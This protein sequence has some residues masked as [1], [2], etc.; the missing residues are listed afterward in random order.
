MMD[1]LRGL[2]GVGRWARVAAAGRVAGLAWLRGDAAGCQA[3][4]DS[5]RGLAR[6]HPASEVTAFT[7]AALLT[8]AS[9]D[10]GRARAD[11]EEAEARLHAVCIAAMA[12]QWQQAALV[13][14]WAAGDHDAAQARTAR[15]EG[16]SGW[17]VMGR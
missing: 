12:P 16:M 4:L 7:S 14:D 10:P 5:Q 11:L 8:V 2:A 3:A 6:G 13:C 15:L 1:R 9:G 17:L